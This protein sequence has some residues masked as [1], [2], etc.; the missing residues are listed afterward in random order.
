MKKMSFFAL[1]LCFGLA[2]SAQEPQLRTER[3]NKTTFG[4]RAG[5]NFAKFNLSEFASGSEPDVNTKTSMHAGLFVNAPLG[6]SF[7]IQPGVEY[8][9]Q[10]SKMKMGT[11][12]SEQDM[13]YVNVP[14]M[15]QWRSNGGFFLETGPQPGF[16]ISAK[17]G[18]NGMAEVDNKD[19]YET[20]DLSWGA[21]L[22]WVSR[23][24]LGLNARYNH[25]LTNT[26]DD[27]TP[28]T[29]PMGEVKNQVIQIG[30]VYH[31]GAHK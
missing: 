4:L 16:L 31:F 9:G 17:M 22:G 21:G 14:I 10:G 18:G 26:L 20:F 7:R 2:V 19:D 1:A 23:V 27:D 28:G 3:S 11:T 15:L 8:S 12:N 6:G 25:G 29:T 13:H 5:L 24:G 30:L